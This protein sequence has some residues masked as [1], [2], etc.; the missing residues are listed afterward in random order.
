[1]PVITL[2]D[3]LHGAAGGAHRRFE[4]PGRHRGVGVEPH[5]AFLRGCLAYLLD[6]IQRMRERDHLDR[7][8][9]RL[10]A[11]EPWNFSC[12]S[13]RSIARIRSGRSGWPIGLR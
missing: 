1:L 10:L 3:R 7:C 11:C 9:R 13:A 4:C 5:H 6:V 2:V 12:S 8:H